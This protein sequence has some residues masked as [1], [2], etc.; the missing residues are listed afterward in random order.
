MR[1]RAI[2][3]IVLVLLVALVAESAEAQRR[4]RRRTQ[5]TPTDATTET[6]TET[7][8]TTDATGTTTTTTPATPATGTTHHGGGATTGPASR[9]T[10]GGGPATPA[11]TTT[12]PAGE[13]ATDDAVAADAAE[14]DL[15]PL[16]DELT[17]IMDELV[18]VRS[19]VAVLG[20]QLFR[21]KVRVVVQNRAGDETSLARV[22]L[23]LDGAPIFRSDAGGLDAEDGR[24][25]FEGF[26]APGPHVITIEA[27]QRQRADG[28]YRYTLRDAYRF[29]VLRDKLTEV[30]IILDDDS[31]IAEDF[32]DDEEGEYDVRTRVRVATRGL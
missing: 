27:E 24:Q 1:S 8:G 11:A 22:A 32:P 4:R 7:T 17:S 5:P 28:D 3:S 19:R 21:T 26:A 25:V 18:Q 30:T 20:R 13:A 9:Q 14:P 12:S 10:G 23:E 2:A 6:T 29:E 16:R 15:G 31:E